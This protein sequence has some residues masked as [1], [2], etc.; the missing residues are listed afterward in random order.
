MEVRLL[1]PLELAESGRPI[2]WRATRRSRQGA[3]LAL[4]V[5]HANQVV[6]SERLLVELWGEDA[7]PSAVNALQAAVSRLRRALP[8]GRLVTRAPGYLLRAYPDELD[9]DR[10]QRLL[11]AGQQA[12]AA[13]SAAEAAR[14]LRL[15][16]GVW[17]GPALA[18]FRY[19]PFAQTEI[20]R[21]EELRLVCLEERIEAELALGASSE[22]VG[23]L[24]TV[25]V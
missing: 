25:L 22:L 15:A 14:T 10:F 8:A 13:G 23:E 12:L 11:A 5:L 3:V 2:A 24:L 19:E 7:P 6:P 21:L 9:L 4:L 16:L 18:D 17:R 20:A 1:G